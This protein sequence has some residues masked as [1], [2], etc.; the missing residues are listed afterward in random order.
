M[1]GNENGKTQNGGT[2]P[3]TRIGTDTENHDN[4]YWEKIA[5]TEGADSFGE[6]VRQ[7][8]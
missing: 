5:F 2:N 6:C 1:T 3:P 4:I 7:H 8:E